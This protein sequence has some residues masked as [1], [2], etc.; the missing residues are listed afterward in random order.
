MDPILEYLIPY[1]RSTPDSDQ[2]G[3]FDN[4]IVGEKRSFEDF[5][6][7]ELDNSDQLKSLVSDLAYEINEYQG[8]LRRTKEFQRH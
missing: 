5:V 1:I 3:D 2:S 6:S 7:D 8:M 4:V